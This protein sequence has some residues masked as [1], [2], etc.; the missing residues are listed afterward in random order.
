MNWFA[1]IFETLSAVSLG[2][3]AAVSLG[4]AYLVLAMREHIACWYAAFLSTAISVYVF[5]QVS[6]LMES[7]LNVY[8][9]AM[10][11][12]GWYQWR[13]GASS[14]LGGAQPRVLPVS[15]WTVGQHALAVAAIALATLISGY[16]L[17][18]NSTAALPYL[19]S[20]TTWG[21]VLT[22]YMVA[23][24]ILENWIYWF[25]IDAVSIGLYLDR[26]LYLYAALFAL[27]LV[28][29]VFGYRSWSRSLRAS[30]AT[31]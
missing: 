3:W 12:Y 11:V 30:H 15:T 31:A 17:S 26:G 16:L 10:A 23:R 19:D 7:T 9:M 2:E 24:K 27:Y 5:W 21:S 6:L 28:L 8:Y 14:D 29:V 20:F 18:Q 22:T 13:Q 1:P 25:V 4:V